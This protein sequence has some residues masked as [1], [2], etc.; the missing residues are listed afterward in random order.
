MAAN[1]TRFFALLRE[2]SVS[3]AHEYKRI[4]KEVVDSLGKRLRVFLGS[5][6]TFFR[7]TFRKGRQRF[8]VMFI[9]HSEKKIFNFHISVFSLVF[10]FVLLRA[11]G[12]GRC[13]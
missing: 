8:T 10:V 6:L 3:P 7:F 12:R 5:I 9:P 1:H 13:P 4:E 11:A 2:C